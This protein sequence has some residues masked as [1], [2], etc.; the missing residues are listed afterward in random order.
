MTVITHVCQVGMDIIR[1]G[2]PPAVFPLDTAHQ[3]TITDLVDTLRASTLIGMAAPQIGRAHRIFV[4]E[5]RETPFRKVGTEPLRIFVNPEIIAASDAHDLGYEGCG[6]VANSDL[7]GQVSR[8]ARVTL[9]WQ[10]P[11]GGAHEEEFSGL[12]ARLVQHEL[13]HLNGIVFMDRLHSS[14]SLMSGEIFRQTRT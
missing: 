14:K 6:S 3:Q 5:I 8:P 7:F 4:T 11:D 12:M 9:R 13:D 2:T 1:A 10:D